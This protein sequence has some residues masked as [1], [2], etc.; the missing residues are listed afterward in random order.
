[1]N[2]EIF[3]N[4][5]IQSWLKRVYKKSQYCQDSVV[6]T[7]PGVTQLSDNLLKLEKQN[8]AVNTKD[9]LSLA[10]G[11]T[12]QL[13]H[14]NFSMNNVRNRIK[15][16][17]YFLSTAG[18]LPTTLLLGDDLPIE[19]GK[20]ASKITYHPLSKYPRHTRHNLNEMGST[21]PKAIFLLSGDEHKTWY[22]PQCQNNKHELTNI[23]SV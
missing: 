15:N 10:F 11:S 7:T 5:N 14:A 3:Y 9:F 4:N 17:L 13:E 16:N 19:K 2:K 20:E 23:V 12:I 1:M 21:Q 8:S 6:K 18:D 22:H